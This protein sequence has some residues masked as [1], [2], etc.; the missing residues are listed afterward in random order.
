KAFGLEEMSR[1]QINQTARELME[2]LT[3]FDDDVHFNIAN[4]IWYRDTFSVEDAFINTNSRY[5]DAEIT[6]ADF[7]DPET[8]EEINQWVDDKTEGLIEEIVQS[9]I[10]PM[11]VMYLINA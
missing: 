8:V 3:G 4:S 6:A 7:N 10:D 11:A 1:D 5:Y 9:P 2:L